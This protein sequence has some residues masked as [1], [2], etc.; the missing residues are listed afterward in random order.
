MKSIGF[1]FVVLALLFSPA[2]AEVQTAPLFIIERNKNANVVHYDAQL[3]ADGRL[4]S[5]EAVIAY[6][7]L[8]AEDGRRQ[9]LSWIEKKAAYGLTVTCDPSVR[10]C[11]MTLAAAP[12]YQITVKTEHHAARAESMISGRLAILEKFYIEASDTL[13]GPGV[14]S[15][16]V[17]GKDVLTGESLR[18][19]MLPK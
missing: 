6:W 14:I 8:L 5:A 4:D 11:T 13:T 7:I 9:E 19:K 3:T 17:H 1:V 18:E 2:A 10:N 15:I 16:E 12:E